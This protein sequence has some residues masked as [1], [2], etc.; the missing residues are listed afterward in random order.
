MGM[1]SLD[2]LK[3][4]EEWGILN[5][6]ETFCML[7]TSRGECF[8]SKRTRRKELDTAL[9]CRSSV[10]KISIN[11]LY[12]WGNKLVIQRDKNQKWF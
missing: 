5:Q 3:P 9:F 7:K 10:V 12:F 8:C 11:Q 4:P 2:I 6:R 1:F